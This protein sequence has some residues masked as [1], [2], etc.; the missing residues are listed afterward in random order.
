MPASISLLPLL[1]QRGSKELLRRKRKQ[2]N[3]IL[4]QLVKEKKLLMENSMKIAK[5]F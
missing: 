4:K 2:E 5:I 1:A 3:N